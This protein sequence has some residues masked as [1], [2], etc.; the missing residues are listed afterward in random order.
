MDYIVETM[1]LKVVFSD[2]TVPGEGEHKI[3]QFIRELRQ[4]PNYNPN[5]VH[6]IHGLVCFFS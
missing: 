5:T 4:D 6:A 1:Q 2:W 3:F